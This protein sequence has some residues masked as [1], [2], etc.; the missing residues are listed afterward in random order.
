MFPHQNVYGTL[1]LMKEKDLNAPITAGTT[2]QGP[3]QRSNKRSS[4]LI[5]HT[6]VLAVL[7]LCKVSRNETL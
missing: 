5:C 3:L 1:M 2:A 4:H 7:V 6:Q